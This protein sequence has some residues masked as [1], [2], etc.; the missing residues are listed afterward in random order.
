MNL[1]LLAIAVTSGLFAAFTP[2]CLPAYPVILN[3][4]SRQGEDRRLP[5]LSFAAGLTLTFMVF[6]V[7]VGVAL[8]RIGEQALQ[9]LDTIYLWMYL[10]AAILCFLFAL[11]SLGKIS[12]FGRTFG[13][14]VSFGH[15]AFGAFLTGAVFATVVSPCS[16]PFILTGILPILLAKTTVIQGLLLM[17]SFSFSLS[18]PI[19]IL[20][21]FS[22]YAM[23]S[24]VKAHTRKIELAS[25]AFLIL[26]CLYFLRIIYIVLTGA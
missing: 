3:I 24:W 25:A 2:C 16:L 21:L 26:A 14:K 22:G 4:I 10:V 19:L 20:G 6:Y 9:N 23:D 5:A 12:F 11:Q 15:G 17:F 1:E 7:A 8:K 13:L 18:L